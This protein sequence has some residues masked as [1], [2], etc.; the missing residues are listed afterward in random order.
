[1]KK[2]IALI[3]ALVML[4]ALS[5]CGGSSANPA[6]SSSAAPASQAGKDTLVVVTDS[7]LGNMSPFGSGNSFSYM[8]DQ[9][10]EELFMLGYDMEYTPKLAESWD[11]VDDTH[12]TF[13]LREGLKDSAGNPITASDVL[14]SMKLYQTDASYSQYV[15]HVD[16]DKT[17][18]TDDRTVDVYFAD[19]NAFAFSQLAGIRIVTKAAWEASPDQ[20]VTNPVGSGPYKLKE[21]V[22][23]SYFVLE[24]NENYWGEQP[25]IK[26]V[27]FNIVSEPSQR[28]TQLETGAADLVMSLQASDV[29]YISEKANF[30]VMNHISVQTMTMFFNMDPV[31]VMSSKE[32]R[33]GLCYAIDNSA[34]NA[35]AYG[36]FCAP[37]TAFFSTGMT[38]YTDDMAKEIY[39]TVNQDKANELFAASGVTGGDIRIATDGSPAETTIAQMIQP[40]LINAGFNVTI[41]A[42]DAATIWSVAADPSQWDLLL[43]I[44][45]APS[46]NGLDEMT[47]FLAGLNFSKWSGENFDTA[48]GL[49]MQASNTVDETARLELTKQALDIVEDDVPAYGI[50]Q[51]AQ[52]FA[53]SSN[54]N[55][56]VWNQAS[57]YVADLQFS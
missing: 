27:R 56:R 29:K 43:M 15:A 14:F 33:Q 30:D 36:G 49:L 4:M 52:S 7:D 35:M 38:D 2:T 6:S 47:A 48:V 50:V 34:M 10:Y 32:L 1:M 40:I 9:V 12:Y 22:G 23:G 16:F 44:A 28:T 46:G 31:S 54:L 24:A 57:L 18:A 26:E 37:S 17:V 25:T 11:K 45:A 5:A 20:M 53:Y 42:Y 55:F 19:T 51:I 3:L 13:H 8:Q 21:Y 39:T 41:D